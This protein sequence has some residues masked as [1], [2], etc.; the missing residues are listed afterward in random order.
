MILSCIGD[1]LVLCVDMLSK[2]EADCAHVGLIRKRSCIE[3]D[4]HQIFLWKARNPF[5]L[6]ICI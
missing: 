2:K 6:T 1:V 4:D 5:F 3:R